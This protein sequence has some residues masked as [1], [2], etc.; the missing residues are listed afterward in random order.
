MACTCRVR[1]GIICATHAVL[2]PATSM[3]PVCAMCS[4][5][6]TPCPGRRPH[7]CS[8]AAAATSR[9]RLRARPILLRVSGH[10][11]RRLQEFCFKAAGLG[12]LGGKLAWSRETGRCRPGSNCQHHQPLPLPPRVSRSQRRRPLRF[13]QTRAAQ[14]Q[15][16]APG[17][18]GTAAAWQPQ[19]TAVRVIALAYLGWCSNAGSCCHKAQL[20]SYSRHRLLAPPYVT[21]LDWRHCFPH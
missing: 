13:C 15:A 3:V 21:C 9:S 14:Q 7:P 20:P 12:G 5:P 10:R 2:V 19:C 4:S 11:R 17:S 18:L 8:V 16:S 1:P 6:R